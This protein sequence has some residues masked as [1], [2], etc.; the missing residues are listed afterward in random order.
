M[1]QLFLIGMFALLGVLAFPMNAVAETGVVPAAHFG[2][3]FEFGDE[4]EL[5]GGFA[6]WA[7]AA[8]FPGA[9]PAEPGTAFFFTPGLEL[10]TGFI[11]LLTGP[12]QISPQVR[13]GMAWQGNHEDSDESSSTRQMSDLKLQAILG[14]R[15]AFEFGLDNLMRDRRDEDAMRFGIDVTS[16]GLLRLTEPIFVPNV[17]T[18][19]VDVNRDGSVDRVGFTLGVGF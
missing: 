1:K 19:I 16:A 15:W 11:P 3:F 6:L 18:G 4:A 12:N 5:A 10:R 7:G 9:D 2:V 14:Y 13:L 17:L 8:I